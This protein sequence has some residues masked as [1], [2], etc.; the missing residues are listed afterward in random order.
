M[1]V[2]D[3]AGSRTTATSCRSPRS[4][5]KPG[6]KWNAVAAIAWSPDANRFASNETYSCASAG[7]NETQCA[8]VRN[9]VGAM[10]LPLQRASSPVMMPF[11]SKSKRDRKSTRLNSS[12]SQIS[13]AVFCLKKKNKDR[14]SADVGERARMLEAGSEQ[15]AM[16]VAL[17]S[18]DIGSLKHLVGA[19]M[20]LVVSRSQ[21][22]IERG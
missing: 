12:H 6:S 1:F 20:K 15:R 7:K 17:Q 11:P 19:L 4:C 8:A 13:Y 9:T 22:D 5:P 18:L 10:R 2:V 16:R 14:K 21:R 3:P